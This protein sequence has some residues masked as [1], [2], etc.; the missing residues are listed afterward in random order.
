[1]ANNAP[2]PSAIRAN[3]A[4]IASYSPALATLAASADSLGHS[5]GGP[6]SARSSAVERA[7]AFRA[8]LDALGERLAALAAEIATARQD[9]PAA[10]ASPL[11][12]IADAAEW[13]AGSPLAVPAAQEVQA[14]RD[15]AAGLVGEMPDRSGYRCPACQMR[16]YVVPRL[17]RKPSA[18]G[19][20][21]IYECPVCGFRA[22]I[23]RPGPWNAYRAKNTLRAAWRAE[24]FRT[25]HRLKPAEAA[26]L[27]GMKDT[28]RLRQWIYRG[29]LAKDADGLVALADVAALIL[30]TEEKA[31]AK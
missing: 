29:R 28:N 23:E 12:Y 11:A 22:R 16:A 13:L 17:E 1:M 5:G 30:G 19:Y 10:T 20:G 31:P 21:D 2:T 8:S 4:D 14:V 26:R 15:A 3:L 18:H 27:V 24:L 6:A 9:P 25:G 7:V